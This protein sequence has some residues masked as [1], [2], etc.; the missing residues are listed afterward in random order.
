MPGK[1]R[2]ALLCA[3]DFLAARSGRHLLALGGLEREFEE[4]LLLTT[5]SF[6]QAA[7]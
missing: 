3:P 2:S 5:G 7:G 6:L 4:D 1:R